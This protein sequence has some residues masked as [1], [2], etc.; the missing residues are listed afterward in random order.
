MV[1]FL[2]DKQN[3]KVRFFFSL[4]FFSRNYN[5][6]VLYRAFNSRYMGSIPINSKLKRCLRG[7]S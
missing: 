3:T 2:F 4:V 1:K 6:M 5:I 7:I